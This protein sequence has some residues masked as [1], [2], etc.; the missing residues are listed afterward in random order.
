VVVVEDGI[1]RSPRAGGLGGRRHP[2]GSSD[3]MDGPH[4]KAF[5]KSNPIMSMTGAVNDNGKRSAGVLPLEPS[6]KRRCIINY[7]KD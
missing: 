6:S 1:L 2:A 7:E 4:T 3:Y 5:Y